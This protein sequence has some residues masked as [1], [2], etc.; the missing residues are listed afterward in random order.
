M[1]LAYFD[2][3][4]DDGF[5]QY[6]SPLFALCGIYV[7]H[8]RWQA[9][10]DEVVAFRRRLRETIGLPLKTEIHTKFLLLDKRP[11]RELEIPTTKRVGVL[12]ECCALL[13]RLPLRI[14]NIVI[15]KP[16]LVRKD[17]DVLDWALTM[18]VQRIENDLDPA[19]ESDARFLLISDVGRVGKMRT[20][21]RRLRQVNY[22]PSRLGLEP[23]R[24]DIRTL[25]E[26]PLPKPSGESYMIQLAD[27]VAF[28][29]YLY[30][31]RATGAGRMHGRMPSAVD[32]AQVNGWMTALSPVL[33]R[34]A[35]R[36]DPFGVVIHP[37]Q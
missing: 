29:V 1:H 36:R 15:V 18:G 19:G 22:I 4:G 27:M 34:W 14:V 10:L 17:F 2:E 21:T 8:L 25:I 3:S 20:T 30:A 16:R 26:D 13:A 37:P 28:I 33:N 11:Y 23:V 12:T 35:S 31:L 24:R 32:D 6:S 5:P 9:V 7:H